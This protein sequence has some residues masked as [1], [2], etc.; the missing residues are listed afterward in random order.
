MASKKTSKR[1]S[2]KTSAA[3]SAAASAS[4]LP[5]SSNIPKGMKQMGGGYAPTW[6]PEDIGESIHG[7]VTS[8]VKMVPMKIGRKQVERRVMELTAINGSG[9]RWAVWESAALGELFDT[10]TER[11]EGVEVFLQYDGLGRKKAGQNPP[12]LFTVAIAE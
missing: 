10:I 12:K 8:E 9:D 3:K 6:K 11:G 2:K 4:S 1:T 7:T 5:Q